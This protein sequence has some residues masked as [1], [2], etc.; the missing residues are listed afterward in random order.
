MKIWSL[1]C[2]LHQNSIGL[3]VQEDHQDG[4][5]LSPRSLTNIANIRGLICTHHPYACQSICSITPVNS[6]CFHLYGQPYNFLIRTLRCEHVKAYTVKTGMIARFWYMCIGQYPFKRL[7]TY[8]KLRVLFASLQVR[9]FTIWQE[10]AYELP[11]AAKE[12]REWRIQKL[13][14]YNDLDND[15]VIT[16]EEILRPGTRPQKDEL[17]EA[18]T[19]HN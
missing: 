13:F 5:H 18:V 1:N 19:S 12:N 8:R 6:C 7:L 16:L 17:W 9:K 10:E 11:D 3:S 4:E 14:D 2:V 15:G